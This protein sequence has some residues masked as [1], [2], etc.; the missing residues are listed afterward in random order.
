MKSPLEGASKAHSPSAQPPVD[1]SRRY[2]GVGLGL[3]TCKN[4]SEL[5][6]SQDPGGS[7]NGLL[8]AVLGWAAALGISSIF[9]GRGAGSWGNPMQPSMDL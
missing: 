9:G 3:L 5:P 1:P 8:S 7:F 4:R 6:S 2:L